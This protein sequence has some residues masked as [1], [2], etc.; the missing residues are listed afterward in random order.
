MA[1]KN[2]EIE[3]NLARAKLIESKIFDKEL[4]LEMQK[5]YVKYI[6]SQ[7]QISI[8]IENMKQ[9][10]L[11]KANRIADDTLD[12]RIADVERALRAQAAQ[13]KMIKNQYEK[14]MTQLEAVTKKNIQAVL[15]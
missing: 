12:I 11:N 14:M 4:A 7:S 6:Q 15:F 10:E 8:E 9:D 2:I 1:H 3:K 5:R 13:N